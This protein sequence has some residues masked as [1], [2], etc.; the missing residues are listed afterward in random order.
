M[1][2]PIDEQE[3]VIQMDRNGD[4]ARIYTTDALVIAKLDKIY[5]RY[6]VHKNGRRIV[7]VEYRP[8]KKLISYRK[9]NR[10]LALSEDERKRRADSLKKAR[11]R[12]K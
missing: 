5:D 3:T 1:T 9:G 12:K 10:K 11:A 7:G 2:I 8:A 6:K 4:Y